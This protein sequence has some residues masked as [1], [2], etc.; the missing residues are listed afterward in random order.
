MHEQGGRVLETYSLFF[1]QHY[2]GSYKAPPII[3][4][5]PLA[6]PLRGR[7]KGGRKN[8]VT[9]CSTGTLDFRRKS[10]IV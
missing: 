4:P 10:N 6:Y 3:S 8:G 5:R 1:K 7:L 9:G 2:K